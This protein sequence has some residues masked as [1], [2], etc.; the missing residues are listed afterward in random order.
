MKYSQ[1]EIDQ[2]IIDF[3]KRME[4][5]LEFCKEL[6]E[7]ALIRLMAAKYAYYILSDEFMKDEAYDICESGWYVM[8]RALGILSEDDTSPC[9]DFDPNHPFAERGMELAHKF[10]KKRAPK[11]ETV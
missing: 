5:E 7:T 8:G 2:G 6:Y 1:T 10:I 4:T 11:R 3:Q 9:I